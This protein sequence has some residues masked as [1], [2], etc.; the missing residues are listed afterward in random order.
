MSQNI[1][2]IEK[3]YVSKAYKICNYDVL[4]IEPI[5]KFSECDYFVN[6]CSILNFRTGEENNY[7][8]IT[9]RYLKFII[10]SDELKR[11]NLVIHNNYKRV[12]I[13]KNSNF[14]SYIS[15]WYGKILIDIDRENT[16]FILEVINMKDTDSLLINFIDDNLPIIDGE[17]TVYNDAR[18]IKRYHV[19][20]NNNGCD[21]NDNINFSIRNNYLYKEGE[22]VPCFIGYIKLKENDSEFIILDKLIVRINELIKYNVRKYKSMREPII[23]CVSPNGSS[24]FTAIKDFNCASFFI[25]NN[26]AEYNIEIKNRIDSIIAAETEHWKREIYEIQDNYIKS[27]KGSDIITYYLYRKF[28]EELCYIKDCCNVKEFILKK[29]LKNIHIKSSIDCQPFRFAMYTPTIS[30]NYEKLPLI[31]I[32]ASNTFNTYIEIY[33]SMYPEGYLIVEC[34]TR[35]KHFGNEI[36]ISSVMEIIKYLKSFDFIDE[37]RIYLIGH[38]SSGTT[39]T[40]LI[41]RYPYL[42]AG[43]LTISCLCNT[44]ILDNAINNKIINVCGALDPNKKLNFDEKKGFF[45]K[46][47]NSLNI[48]VENFNDQVAATLLR[49]SQLINNLLEYKANN[50]SLKFSYVSDNLFYNGYNGMHIIKKT[51][52]NKRASFQYE[53]FSDEIKIHTENVQILKIKK[54]TD[55]KISINDR[56]LSER[57]KAEAFINIGDDAVNLLDNFSEYDAL[58]YRL[59]ISNMYIGDLRIYHNLPEA[60]AQFLLKFSKPQSV[61]AV[62]LDSAILVDYP[63]YDYNENIYSKLDEH[64]YLLANYDV[65]KYMDNFRHKFDFIECFVDGFKYKGEFYKGDYSII[66]V[67]PNL[68]YIEKVV[69]FIN[70]NNF[71]M[72][73][74]NFFIRNVFLPSDNATSSYYRNFAL[75]CYQNIFYY[76]TVSGSAMKALLTADY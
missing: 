49:N 17:I 64:N 40:S 45:Q 65:N 61:A 1:E 4:S 51:D 53:E 66:Q 75:I 19:L 56:L 41:S 33:A 21:I 28:L 37:N 12:K 29:G 55:K 20:T 8:G 31:I 23:V 16:E 42:F 34:S 68:S 36:S 58:K 27:R 35:G 9:V 50:D 74:R 73:K 14:L 72:A 76:I 63:I 10:E 59:E 13:W 18:D 25:N 2:I 26:L 7:D 22:E 47:K 46:S 48:L 69:T 30:S 62:A 43:C 52:Y 15:D 60:E 3:C 32:L 5:I 44:S 57:I 54:K 24:E 6:E 38:S 11:I 70:Y 67:L 71:K 39:A